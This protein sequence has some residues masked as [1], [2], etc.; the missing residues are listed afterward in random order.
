MSYVDRRFQSK[1]H[2][3]EKPYIGVSG[4]TELQNVIYLI[5]SRQV[6]APLEVN[7]RNDQCNKSKTYK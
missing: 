6:N 1:M 4:K 7:L 3:L 2:Q 5:P